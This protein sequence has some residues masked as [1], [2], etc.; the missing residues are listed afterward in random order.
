MRVYRL[1][2]VTLGEARATID[3]YVRA[4]ARGDFPNAQTAAA[5]CRVE[6]TRRCRG[7]KVVTLGALTL[8]LRQD[9]HRK[10]L[11]YAK[12]RWTSEDSRVAERYARAVVAG[13]YASVKLAASAC[14]AELGRGRGARRCRRPRSAVKMRIYELCRT[15]GL[16]TSAHWTE[17]ERRVVNR[18]LRDLYA[19]RFPRVKPAAEACA[20]ELRQLSG[21]GGGGDSVGAG[22]H[23]TGAV[24][25]AMTGLSKRFGLPRFGS[26]IESM[27]RRLYEKYARAVGGGHY[28]NA[29]QAASA[30]RRE[31][32][33]IYARIGARGPLH[34]R[35]LAPRSLIGTQG[36]ILKA[37]RRL[38][39]QY[40]RRRWLPAE[41]RI[42]KGWLRWY[43]RYHRVRRLEPLTQAANG[44]SED[45]AKNGF[46]RTPR[47][48]QS[49]LLSMRR[50]SEGHSS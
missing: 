14:H 25:H 45:L 18:Y 4:L 33:R 15:M 7:R 28:V 26:A 27:E 38:S 21:P 44:L 10:Q 20:R 31:V 16:H 43:S 24:F 23:S 37:V 47:A 19:G 22:R 32:T 1:K 29:V 12:A 5:A 50:E 48:C 11:A 6:L 9:A 30:C 49:R 8:Q 34:V 42:F 46:R 41:T 2:R 35:R 3:K 40:P 36:A 39:I 17:E 13:R